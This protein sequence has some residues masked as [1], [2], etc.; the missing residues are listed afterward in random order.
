MN[1]SQRAAGQSVTYP[2]ER[3]EASATCRAPLRAKGPAELDPGHRAIGG[4]PPGQRAGGL[5][6]RDPVD[7][8]LAARG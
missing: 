7:Q 3:P 4:Q 5:Y 2:T 8:R 6:R 1:G